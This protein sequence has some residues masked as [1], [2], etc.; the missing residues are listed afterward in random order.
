L[1]T[2]QT[3]YPVPAARVVRAIATSSATAT[4]AGEAHSQI[5]PERA[6][7]Q[8]RPLVDRSDVFARV[9]ALLRGRLPESADGRR[10]DEDTGLLGQGIG[11]DSVDVLELVGAIEADF[12]L[13]IDDEALEAEHFET[14]GAVVTFVMGHLW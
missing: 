9:A 4:L 13:T 7:A 1:T 2:D 5:D 8:S 11:L 3:R 14:I 10:L 12:G 6:L